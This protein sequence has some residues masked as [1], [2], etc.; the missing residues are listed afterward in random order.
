M[1]LA[2]ECP[3]CGGNAFYLKRMP[4]S[5][6][7]ARAEDAFFKDGSS[8]ASNTPIKCQECGKYLAGFFLETKRIRKITD[9]HRDVE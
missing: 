5:G 3:H 4:S 9:V 2:Y 7:R 8:P 1:T 6:E